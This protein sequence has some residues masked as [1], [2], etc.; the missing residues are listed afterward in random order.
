M[1]IYPER[2]RKW[3]G[4]ATRDFLSRPSTFLAL[5]VQLVV[6]VSDL[7]F[8]QFL[9]RCSSTHGAPPCPVICKSGGRCPSVLYR[10]GATGF[11]DKILCYSSKRNLIQIKGWQY[12]RKFETG[13][14]TV[15]G[16]NNN[17]K[18]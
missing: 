14:K 5:K 10:V 2:I 7:Q 6:L 1:T 13:H 12:H 9:V 18:M 4:A 16:D 15:E 8:G 3:G 17:G 11:A